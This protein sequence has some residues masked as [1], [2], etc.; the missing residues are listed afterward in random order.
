MNIPEEQGKVLDD[1]ASSGDAG[2][3]DWAAELGREPKPATNGDVNKQPNGAADKAKPDGNAKPE[4]DRQDRGPDGNATPE[5]EDKPGV[6]AHRDG[7]SE[8]G[9]GPN[10]RAEVRRLKQERRQLRE[11][12]DASRKREE[13]LN[14]RLAALEAKLSSTSHDHKPN[15]TE[16]DLLTQ[17]LTDPKKVFADEKKSLQEGMRELFREEMAKARALE[18]SRAQRSSAIKTLESIKDFDLERDEDEVFEIMAEEYGLDE[19]DVEHLLAT[20]PVKTAAWIKKAW[21]KKHSTALDDATKA[22]KA[23]A[24]ATTAGG[25]GSTHSKATLSDVNSR[26]KGAKSGEDLDRLWGDVEKL[27]K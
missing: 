7:A 10:V 19:E 6:D 26:A 20:R 1:L 24:R 8:R 5:G 14:S 3:K 23:A 13:T 18:E 27:T 22:D 12:R 2:A 17:L 11:E 4:G 9:G 15:A 25:G 21:E 16:E